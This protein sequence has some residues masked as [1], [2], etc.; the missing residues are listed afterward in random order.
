MASFWVCIMRKDQINRGLNKIDCKKFRIL[1]AVHVEGWKILTINVIVLLAIAPQNLVAGGP[2][3]IAGSTYFN[4]SVMGQPIHWNNGQLNYYVDQGE[5]SS[6]MNNSQARAMVDAA[7]AEW[8]AI[9]TAGITLTDAGELNED[10]NGSSITVVNGVITAP[11]DVTP[12]ATAY[13]VGVI[14]DAD[15]TVI[16]A[17][18][19]TG[20]SD[21]SDCLHNVVFE[22]MDNLNTNATI[23]HAM[24]VLNG[25][26]A[27]NATQQAMMSADLERAFGRVLGLDYAQVDAVGSGG[28]GTNWSVMQPPPGVYVSGLTAPLYDD[29]AA[30]NRIYPI[31]S[32]NLSSFPGKQLT[33]ANTI[34]IQ[35]TISFKTGVGMQGV[36][37]VARPLDASGNPMSQYGV[38]FVSGSYFRG[39][40]GNAILGFKDSYGNPLTNYGSTNK[41][42]QGFF[43]LSGI[44]L[45][46]GV[47]SA[48][49]QISFETINANNILTESVGPYLQGSPAPSGSMPTVVLQSL[50]AGATK[51]V[52]ETI[53]NSA[54]GTSTQGLSS[55][56]EPMQLPANGMWQGGINQIGESQWFEFPVRGGRIFTIVAQPLNEIGAASGQ[57]LLPSIGVW[58]GYDPAA[59]APVGY[60]AGPDATTPGESSLQIA[61]SG[62]DM[63][64][65]AVADERGDGRPDYAYEGWVLYADTVTPA[66]IPTSGGVIA[67]NGMGF[68]I[69]DTV[70][71]GGQPAQV[72]SVTAN[73]IT[74][75]AP[76]SQ[77]G[78]TGSVDVEVD[79][80]ASTSAKAVIGDGISYDAGNGDALNLVTAPMGTVPIGVPLPFTVT[81]EQANLAP[82]PG[83]TVTYTVT[84]G[85]ATLG[86]GQSSCAVKATGDGRATMNVTDVDGNL[87]IITASLTNGANVQA[88]FVGGTPPFMNALN[89]NLSL[90][91]GATANWTVQALVLNYGVPTAGI[92]VVFQPG[93]GTTIQGSSIATSNSNGIAT[94]ILSVGPLSE[95]Q[96]STTVACVNGTS[97]C[98][99]YVAFGARPE[100]AALEAV[101]GTSQSLLD[102]GTPSQVVLRVLDMD[103]NEM[104]GATVTSYQTL[105]AWTPPCQLH[106]V[107][108]LGELLATNV[109]TS[110]SAMDGSVS[111]A[112]ISIPGTATNLVGVAVTG[113]SAS[114]SFAIEELP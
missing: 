89:P 88:Q 108:T 107:C 78:A 52:N 27:A 16:D 71:V 65:M 17:L 38:S 28:V 83:V 66:N 101:S 60:V 40:H 55:A 8:S 99:N 79:D 111:I 42:L 19:G 39:N 103:G 53:Q 110:T 37:V 6:Y 56:E 10:V 104:V 47:T 74:A 29:V 36:N 22:W 100:Y 50:T 67:I 69:N 105:Y 87:S 49:Y 98:A 21:A 24:I 63:V 106:E 4:S 112:P 35:G 75:M 2:K 94:M 86:C 32:T 33:A 58:D 82:A 72:L 5:L 31:T 109:T 41:A 14:F 54:E 43:D 25:L 68:H 64:R 81:A 1:Q 84:Q 97:Y 96:S 34:S 92:S 23:A 13:P 9:P 15:G 95:G 11:A 20:A 113:N 12:S 77:S 70:L 18:F 61:T 59:N 44:P 30:L 62:D 85:T 3:Y 26:C 93:A 76:A 57:K 114:L 45:P 90:A 48:N 73:Q 7:A 51:T 46:P 80:A 102:T 91:A